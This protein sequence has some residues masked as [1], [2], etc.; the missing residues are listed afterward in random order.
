MFVLALILLLMILLILTLISRI[1]MFNMLAGYS[2]RFE[3]P[4]FWPAGR[5]RNQPAQR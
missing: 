1:L 4:R 3:N 2:Q 5:R